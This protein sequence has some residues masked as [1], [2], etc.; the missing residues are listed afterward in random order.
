MDYHSL[1]IYVLGN[2]KCER[3]RERERETSNSGEQQ[4]KCNC[5][6]NLSSKFLSLLVIR[7]IKREHIYIY[8]K[9]GMRKMMKYYT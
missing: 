4:Q 1:T 9:N 7:W 3:E 2:A 5:K 6:K 8:K